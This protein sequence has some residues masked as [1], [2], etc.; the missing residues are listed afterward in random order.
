MLSHYFPLLI[1]DNSLDLSVPQL[2]FLS[3][4]YFLIYLSKELLVVVGCACLFYIELHIE[5][6]DWHYQ[7][8]IIE[9]SLNMLI[10]NKVSLFFLS[11][12]LIR[13]IFFV[14]NFLLFWLDQILHHFLDI[15]FLLELLIFLHYRTLRFHACHFILEIFLDVQTE[16]TIR[17][18]A[19]RYWVFSCLL[20]L[21]CYFESFC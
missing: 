7:I 12:L 18:Y 2:A 13:L 21:C 8:L 17:H 20:L 4:I 5:S 11:L 3:P 6:E 10:S 19:Y 9:N 14:R 16:V 15:W 1:G